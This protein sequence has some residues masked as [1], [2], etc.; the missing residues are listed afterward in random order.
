MLARLHSGRWTCTSSGRS[1]PLPNARRS[2]PSSVPRSPAG[3]AASA[4]RAWTATP[5][6]AATRS[7]PALAAPAGAAR[8]PGSGRLDQPA[9]PELHLAAARGAAG[10]GL[11]RGDLLRAVRD[12]PP[13]A[14]RGPRLRRHRVPARRRGRDLCRPGADA[15]SRRR[16]RTATAAS[17]WLR[18]PCLGLCERAP[19]AL[20][21]AA[22]ERRTASRARRR[23]MPP[24]SSPAGRRW[25]PAP[26][27]RRSRR[28]A[29]RRSDSSAAS[30]VVDPASLDDYRANGGYAALA[31]ALEMGRRPSSRRSPLR[32]SWAVAAPRSRPV[33]SG[34][35][36][37]GSP[38]SPT[39]SCATPTSRSPARS[40]TASLI[41]G[42]PFA[43]VEAMTIAAFATGASLG[44]LYI[45][46]RVPGGR[47]GRPRGDRRRARRRTCSAS[48]ILGSGFSFD[49]EVRRGA[50]A[51]ICG[52]E[53]ALFES[54]EGKRG[55]PRNKPP[56]PVEVGLFG[57]P[58]VVNNVETLVNVP[59]ILEMGG[60]AYAAHRHRGLDRPEAVLPVRARRAA[61]RVRGRVRR[62]RSAT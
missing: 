22:G 3:W 15:R 49:I 59:L 19:A 27:R 34:R 11:R 48:D 40:R 32:S 38:P 43:V 13:P 28:P 12:E 54:I 26:T 58:T 16:P 30:G 2:M 52:E 8:R 42:D 39:T 6:A 29:T 57:K 61:R 5:P 25:N 45:R 47:G 4:G 17:G 20:I 44:Y 14:G 37:P 60:D 33:A 10:R 56:F 7:A 31:R 62:R 55:E 50:G 35:P 53:T 9:R 46:G 36:W 1:P 18:S 24:G 41:E 23:S 21:T 51:Y